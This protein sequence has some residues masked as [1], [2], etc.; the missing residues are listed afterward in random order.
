MKMCEHINRVKSKIGIDWFPVE[1]ISNINYKSIQEQVIE[2]AL[3]PDP[4]L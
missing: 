2:E 3:G 1:E 4:Y